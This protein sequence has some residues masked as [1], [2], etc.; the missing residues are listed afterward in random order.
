[1]PKVSVIIPV[2][3]TENY[4]RECLDS[5]LAQTFTDF[6]VLVINDG[7]TDG[8]GRICDEYAQKDARVKVFHKE[9]GGVSSARNLGLDHAKGDWVCFVDSDDEVLEDALQNYVNCIKST[10]ADIIISNYIVKYENGIENSVK[11]RIGTSDLQ[12]NDLIKDIIDGKI[13]GSLC[14]KIIKADILKK[15]RFDPDITY[16]EDKFL[17][18]K[19]LLREPNVFFMNKSTYVYWQRPDSATNKISSKSI[20]SVKKVYDYLINKLDKQQYADQILNLKVTYK[21]MLLK[22]LKPSKDIKDSF[23]EINKTILNSKNISWQQRVLLWFEFRN[24]KIFSR[25][26]FLY[27]AKKM[28]VLQ[29]LQPLYR[30]VRCKLQ[31]EK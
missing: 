4:L 13:H 21:I 16:M 30:A 14:N 1:M 2:Y 12:N 23:P 22:N 18:I 17:L 5:V 27:L 3:N 11:V 19:M 6:E 28:K 20:A 26:Y 31:F 24:I 25:F 7:S 15:F 9:N 29:M 8:S 10:D